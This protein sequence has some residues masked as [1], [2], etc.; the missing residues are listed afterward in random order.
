MCIYMILN[1]FQSKI[2]KVVTPLKRRN[3]RTQR[4]RGTLDSVQSSESSESS[5]DE[6]TLVKERR[7]KVTR[8]KK[9]QSECTGRRA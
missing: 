2:Q 9:H 8:G 6:A 3:R 4:R 7:R 5:G 1:H